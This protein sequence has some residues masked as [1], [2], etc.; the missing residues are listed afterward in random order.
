MTQ[1]S[2]SLL[3][4]VFYCMQVSCCVASC[5][6]QKPLGSFPFPALSTAVSP[7]QPGSERWFWFLMWARVREV[8]LIS[9]VSQGV[10]TSC[11]DLAALIGPW[12]KL[13]APLDCCRSHHCQ[14][15]VEAG[16]AAHIWG[17][18]LLLRDLFP[19]PPIR[20]WFLIVT[21]FSGPELRGMLFFY[22]CKVSCCALQSPL[23]RVIDYLAFRGKSW[24]HVSGMSWGT[25]KTIIKL[26]EIVSSLFTHPS[27]A[28]WF[29]CAVSC[30]DIIAALPCNCNFIIWHLI[31]F[32]I[33]VA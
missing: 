25:N 18:S 9:D 23:P 13:V 30:S 22:S 7:L 20:T 28:L 14:W 19:D 2:P 32:I 21:E 8:V 12:Q 5:I 31:H 15:T 3:E 6:S 4:S 16:I 10:H 17:S 29:F 33:H 27:F 11:W 26:W 1:V 24:S